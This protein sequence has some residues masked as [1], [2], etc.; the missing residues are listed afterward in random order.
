MSRLHAPPSPSPSRAVRTAHPS[1]VGAVAVLAAALTVTTGLVAPAQAGGTDDLTV[2]TV[3]PGDAGADAV[4]RA[5]A[6]L[7][8]VAS[9]PDDATV[10]GDDATV[11]ALE[12]AG[13]DVVRA[14]PYGDTLPGPT[15]AARVGPLAADAAY[16]LPER[17][18]GTEYETFFGGYRTVAAHEEFLADAADAYGEIAEL[19]DYGDSWLKTQGRGGHDLWALRITA[20][21]GSDGDGR[22]Q[23]EA[24]PRFF[25]T[26][27]AHAREIITSELAWRFVVE[28]LDGYGTD[29]QITQLLDTVEIWVGPQNN[30]DGAALVQTGLGEDV[31]LTAAGDAN[32]VS[33]SPAWQRKNLDDTL[34]V[35][36]T[37]PSTS[38]SGNHPGVDLN[39]NFATA[40]GGAS[41]STNPNAATYLGTAPFS[42]PESAAQAELLRELFGEL[43]VG[44]TTPA[45]DD[46]QGVFVNLHSYSDYVIYPYAY[47][48][49]ANVPNLE[50]IKA[51]GFRQSFFNGFDTGKAGEILYDNAGNDIDWVYDRLGVPAYT[52]EIGTAA[53]GGFFPA[54]SR[55][56]T[57]WSDA[58]PAL[59]YAA[60]AAVDPYR[61]PLGP[62]VTEVAVE[63]GADGAVTVSGT[64][65]D[66]TL[67]TNPRSAARRPAV[68]DVTAVQAVVGDVPDA[69]SAVDVPVT[70]SGATATFAGALAPVGG[71]GERQEV[72]VRAQG[73]DGS[74]GPWQTRWL[75]PVAGPS[76][77]VTAEARCLAGKV[78]VAV[79][80]LNTG[81]GPVDL[82]LGTPYGTRSLAAVA[83]GKNAYQAFSSRL[84]EVP[85]GVATVVV[86]DT[87]G[88]TSVEAPYDARACA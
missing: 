37:N 12:A 8:V 81:E 64:A 7:D 88:S 57:F 86:T 11:A 34:Y 50:P 62:S 38:Y 66:D 84:V 40:W 46:R 24:K 36:P 87:S 25:L 72:H 29:P 61:S 2:I 85:G 52:W 41:T 31:R 22:E 19:V 33:T 53:T 14:E 30:P 20:G 70:T 76:V 4:A 15:S 65:S 71:A 63:R 48:T 77:E 44:T 18:A 5:L 73:A 16:P 13:L 74:W 79:R 51:L 3:G 59:L 35:P 23:V 82:T 43:E 21:A 1:R 39:R 67:G 28:L 32:P 75:E 42:E 54:Y 47:D 78:S 80:A 58:R 49:A 83:P 27:Q 6:G 9:G 26:A 17:L 68:Q 56:E 55:V 69:G 45:P 60:G 10:L